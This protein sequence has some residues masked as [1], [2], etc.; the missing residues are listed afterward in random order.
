V[1]HRLWEDA[2]IE[3]TELLQSIVRRFGRV[4]LRQLLRYVYTEHPDKTTRSEIKGQ[5]G[6][7]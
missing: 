5:L 4:P 6:L 2:P 7:T 1:A 3:L